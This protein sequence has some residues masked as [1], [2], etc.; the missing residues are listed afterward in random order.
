M[1]AITSANDRSAMLA[2]PPITIDYLQQC[3]DILVIPGPLSPAPEFSELF[4]ITKKR[5]SDSDVESKAKSTREDPSET[6]DVESSTASKGDPTL[7]TE[8]LS[9]DRLKALASAGQTRGR[10]LKHSGDGHLRSASTRTDS[11]NDLAMGL[12]ELANALILYVYAFWCEDLLAGR[13]VTDP[14]NGRP[15]TKLGCDPIKWRSSFGL[16]EFVRLRAEKAGPGWEAMVAVTN[17]L[18]GL[19][20]HRIQ[21]FERRLLHNEVVKDRE[22]YSNEGTSSTA[23][24]TG[25]SPLSNTSSGGP[26]PPATNTASPPK[27]SSDSRNL[28]RFMDFS[29]GSENA[30]RLIRLALIDG[31]LSPRQFRQN[32]PVT[33]SKSMNAKVDHYD[34]VVIGSP[35]SF[36]FPLD[37]NHGPNAL[38]HAACFA[39]CILDELALKQ[40][41]VGWTCEGLLDV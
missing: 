24:A 19:I 9:R 36:P 6:A 17:L 13:I 4:N 16:F 11:N 37:Q 38:A 12:L 26:T 28:D 40:G 8:L 30:D 23:H 5:K 41:V 39:G 3:I 18:E 2:P 33:W 22:R 10:A 31:T 25:P 20:K 21:H 1:I 35:W 32:L 34:Q 15:I 14:I 29:S 7:P 27:I